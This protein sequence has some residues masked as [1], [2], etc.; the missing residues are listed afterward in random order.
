MFI[1]ALADRGSTRDVSKQLGNIDPRAGAAVAQ[2][3]N[4]K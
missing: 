2:E 4:L 3:K 1:R